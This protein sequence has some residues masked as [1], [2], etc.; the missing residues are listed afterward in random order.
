MNN[1]KIY[2]TYPNLPNCIYDRYE[3]CWYQVAEEKYKS[4]MNDCGRIRH[5]E[6]RAERCFLT[7]NKIFYCH[8]MCD[9]CKFHKE[10]EL[11]SL[12]YLESEDCDPL[13]EEIASPD[14]STEQLVEDKDELEYLIEKLTEIEPN[15]R[16]IIELRRKEEG[17]SDR[18]IARRL[19]IP[20]RTFSDRMT[21]VRKMAIELRKE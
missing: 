11:I 15:L 20:Q 3:K 7:R 5:R 8:G 12:D 21:R 16:L 19:G 18:E 14:P 10:S 1:N 6:Q 4:Y 2:W 9:D 13:I 17:I